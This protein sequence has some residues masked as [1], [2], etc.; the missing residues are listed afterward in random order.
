[1]MSKASWIGDLVL[2][3]QDDFLNSPSLRLTVPD[4]ERRFGLDRETCDAILGV[5]VDGH[6]LT[7]TPDGAYVRWFP[8]EAPVPAYAA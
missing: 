1:M 8:R 4:T 6:V 3:V 2:R 5:L 7:R